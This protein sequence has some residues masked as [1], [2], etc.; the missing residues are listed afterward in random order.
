MGKENKGFIK[1]DRNIFEHWIFQDSEK[2]QKFVDLI[3]LMR[4][5]DETLL[6]GN[7]I[8]TI[9]RG[10][11][12]TSEL[13]LMERWDWSRN[14]VRAY[15]KLLEN[16]GML[17][18][19]GTTNGTTLTLVNYEVYQG[20]STTQGTTKGT[21]EGTT[22]STIQSTTE[23]TSKGTQK[24]KLKKLEEFKA[25][26]EGEER[27]SQLP[28]LFPS[29]QFEELFLNHYGKMAYRT[30]IQPCDIKESDKEVI[31]I[32]PN[33]FTKDILEKKFKKQMELLSKKKVLIE[34]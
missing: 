33:N 13:K 21:V 29:T 1:L 15:L 4:W 11:Y 8:I 32:A 24:K 16:E 10:S 18:K 12:F 5:K 27:S 23:G 17:T 6:I 34:E 31:L 30:W 9:P 14:K 7:K 20:D 26:K 19:K 28:P 2:F 3:Q 22:Q 25:G